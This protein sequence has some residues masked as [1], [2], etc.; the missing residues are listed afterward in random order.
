MK[1]NRY[2]ICIMPWVSFNIET[3]EGDVYPCCMSWPIHSY[4]NI[5]NS[6]FQKIWNS[7]TAQAH[8]A[9]MFNDDYKKF[10]R[11]TCPYILNKDNSLTR[12]KK[13]NTLN[14]YKLISKQILEE[15]YRNRSM[16]TTQPI[17]IQLLTTSLCNLSCIMC[18]QEHKIKNYLPESFYKD[19]EIILPGL[20]RISLLGGELF[21]DKFSREYLFSLT[22]NRINYT[23]LGIVTNGVLLDKYLL[24]KT[25]LFL[26]DYIIVSVNAASSQTYKKIHGKDY[27]YR[28]INNILMLKKEDSQ[29]PIYASFVVQPDNYFEIDG[30]IDFC[31]V[32]NIGAKFVPIFYDRPI[33]SRYI[34]IEMC[35]HIQNILKSKHKLS[36][37][38][39]N[40]LF[41]VHETFSQ[42]L[43]GSSI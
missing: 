34:Y 35:N 21:F 5:F 27:F 23:K 28:V 22:K 4:G 15:I 10:C 6:S 30:F 3:N 29:L 20:Y 16:I 1:N 12:L 31:L 36:K 8:R 43:N 24:G 40:E 42:I 39:K 41:V 7:N 38:I 19:V 18:S 32:N 33:I 9:A 2:P 17:F 11:P 37:E 14:N 26:F 13:L 25:N